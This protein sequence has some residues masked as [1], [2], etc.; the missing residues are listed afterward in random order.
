MQAGKR[1][2]SRP[3]IT[4]RRHHLVPKMQDK[5]QQLELKTQQLWAIS[6]P[7]P[8]VLLTFNIAHFPAAVLLAI[9]LLERHL[10]IMWKSLFQCVVYV[11]HYSPADTPKDS[12]H[13]HQ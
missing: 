10:R 8:F 2:I 3:L 6:D 13:Q 7:V 9:H 4:Q 1:L 5:H 12:T 11:S